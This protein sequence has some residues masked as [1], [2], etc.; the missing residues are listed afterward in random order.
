MVPAP[1][2]HMGPLGQR[3]NSLTRPMGLSRLSDADHSRVAADYVPVVALRAGVR[4]WIPPMLSQYLLRQPTVV[5][6]FNDRVSLR[7]C[8]V[9]LCS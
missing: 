6:P 3:C 8:G 4:A 5:V 2:L 9:V 7:R 1:V